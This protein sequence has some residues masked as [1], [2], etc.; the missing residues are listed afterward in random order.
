MSRRTLTSIRVHSRRRA[1]GLLLFALVGWAGIANAQS[2]PVVL[3]APATEPVTVL[4]AKHVSPA[5]QV[6]LPGEIL[7]TGCST[8]GNGLVG[9]GGPGCGGGD[10]AAGCYPGRKPCD[11][12]GLFGDSCFGR[13][14]GG[15]GNDQN[16]KGSSTNS[17]PDKG[18]N[19]PPN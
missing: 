4:P 16:Q 9:G 8:C 12:A 18:N 19:S 10:C 15:K 5:D 3:P 7:Q 1:A 13:M 6:A 17:S 11:C 14:F 2:T